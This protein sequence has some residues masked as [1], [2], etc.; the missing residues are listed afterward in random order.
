MHWRLTGLL[1]TISLVV[2]S[3]V[4]S[5][6][7]VYLARYG[8]RY[9]EA[10]VHGGHGKTWTSAAI[11]SLVLGIALVIAVAYGRFATDWAKV[12]AETGGQRALSDHEY[13]DAEYAIHGPDAD[14]TAEESEEA[15]AGF[16]A[17]WALFRRVLPA[18]SGFEPTDVAAAARSVDLPEGSL[19]NGAGLRFSAEPARLG[20]NERAAAVIWQWQAVRT[21]EFVWPPT[22]ATGQVAFVPLA[23]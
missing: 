3:V 20:Q 14:A 5:H 16:T 17:G 2:V 23:R 12:A 7:L 11:A 22:Y 6:Q 4:L 10:L 13:G 19:P 9:N 21:Y 8:S 1:T 18:A 15:L